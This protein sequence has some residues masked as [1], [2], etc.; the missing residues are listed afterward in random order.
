MSIDWEWMIETLQMMGGSLRETVLV[1]SLPDADPAHKGALPYLRHA[2]R[3]MLDARESM[4][5]AC[6]KVDD[7]RAKQSREWQEDKEPQF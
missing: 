2:A 6:K 1:A 5:A 7:I 3:G 4:V